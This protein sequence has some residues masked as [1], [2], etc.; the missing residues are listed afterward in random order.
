M[1]SGNRVHFPDMFSRKSKHLTKWVDCRHR[2]VFLFFTTGSC[3]GLFCLLLVSN[4]LEYVGSSWDDFWKIVIWY[5]HWPHEIA[6]LMIFEEITHLWWVMTHG[7]MR[8]QITTSI[9]PPPMWSKNIRLEMIIF[10]I[11]KICKGRCYCEHR[12]KSGLWALCFPKK[13]WVCERSL[14]RHNQLCEMQLRLRSGN[15][16]AQHKYTQCI[17]RLLWN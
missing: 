16:N 1:I 11:V 6:K 7:W 4:C 2:S 3:F 17:E 10:Q 13:G 14:A 12:E 5:G 15:A 8:I 9:H